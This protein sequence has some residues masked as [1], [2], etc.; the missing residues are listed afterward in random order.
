MES[1]FISKI[2]FNFRELIMKKYLTNEVIVKAVKAEIE[3]ILEGSCYSDNIT[4][5]ISD[6]LSLSSIHDRIE[7]SRTWSVEFNEL[8]FGGGNSGYG[9]AT[10][11]FEYESSLDGVEL[12]GVRDRLG[13]LEISECS[14]D[15]EDIRE[16]LQSCIESGT[17]FTLSEEFEEM[18]VEICQDNLRAILADLE[19]EARE[20]L[21]LDYLPIPNINP[22]T[23]IEFFE[24]KEYEQTE[25]VPVI[26]VPESTKAFTKMLTENKELLN[27][28]KIK[29]IY[30]L[31]FH[32][33]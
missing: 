21:V 6:C 27:F 24:R 2:Y 26:N 7:N 23:L 33:E 9:A 3:E 10:Q 30:N 14:T 20:K 15:I 8:A 5:E 31:T 4:N 16:H 1:R 11:F 19:V 25:E 12:Y 28:D 32:Y 18:Y 22:K 13:A 17:H 29:E